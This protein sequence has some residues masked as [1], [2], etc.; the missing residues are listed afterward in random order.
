MIHF[1]NRA[2]T[3]NCTTNL[4]KQQQGSARARQRLFRPP[5]TCLMDT[6]W[7]IVSQKLEFQ[8]RSSVWGNKTSLSGPGFQILKQPGH[9][10][11]DRCVYDPNLDALEAAVKSALEPIYV[12][13]TFTAN[14]AELV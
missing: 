4:I 14:C 13:E 11:P 2:L 3:P 10:L 7:E 8:S 5:S 1:A 9:L 12:N 6:L